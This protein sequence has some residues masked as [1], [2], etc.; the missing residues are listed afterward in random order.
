MFDEV[1][2]DLDRGKI[3]PSYVDRDELR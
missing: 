1:L 2:R 3:A